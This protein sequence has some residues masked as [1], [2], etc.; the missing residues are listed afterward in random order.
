VTDPPDVTAAVFWRRDRSLLIPGA[1]FGRAALE[2]VRTR[3]EATRP[4]PDADDPF[5]D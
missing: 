5:Q 3:S 2:V 4:T 1:D